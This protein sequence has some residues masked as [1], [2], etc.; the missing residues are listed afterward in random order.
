[1]F[2]GRSLNNSTSERIIWSYFF[3]S[4]ISIAKTVCYKTNHFIRNEVP[5]HHHG[6][7]IQH[8]LNTQQFFLC[9]RLLELQ[10]TMKMAPF[11]VIDF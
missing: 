11:D 3:C 4:I 5:H 8:A 9:N 7:E 10:I 2:Q 1:M 6:V